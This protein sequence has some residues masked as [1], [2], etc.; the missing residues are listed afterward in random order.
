MN[1]V[2]KL[3]GLVLWWIVFIFSSSFNKMKQNAERR[4]FKSPRNVPK[5]EV[6]VLKQEEKRP[7]KIKLKGNLKVDHAKTS[8]TVC[9]KTFSSD[10]SDHE[11]LENNLNKLNF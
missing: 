5:P 10:E 3:F 6:K 1:L 7:R 8:H 11:K 9:L 2:T 4:I